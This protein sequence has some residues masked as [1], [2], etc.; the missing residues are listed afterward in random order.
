MPPTRLLWSLLAASLVLNVMYGAVAGVLVPAQIAIA[1]PTGKELTLAVVMTVSS[2]LTFVVHPLVGA[3]SDR[4]RSRWGRRTPWILGGAVASALAMLWLGSATAVWAITLGWLVL[5]PLLNVVEAPLDAVV[6][7]RIDRRTRPRAA[8]VYGAAAAVGVGVGAVIAGAGVSAVGSVYAGLAAALVVTMLAFSWLAPE[9]PAAAVEMPSVPARSAWAD[10]D[11]RLVFAGRFVL[12]LGHQL[13][14]GYL[15]YVVMAFTGSS[16]ADAAGLV[17]MVIGVHLVSIVIGAVAGARLIRDRRVPWIVGSTVVLA[18]SLALP[19]LAPNLAGLLLFAVVGG[20]GR[21][22]YLSADLALML[23][24]LPSSGD[25]GRDL[26]VLGLATI[27]PQMLAP[28]VAGVVLTVT[29][30]YPLL[31]GLASVVVLVSV[32]FMVRVG[33]LASSSRP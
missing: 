29:G 22:V 28:A 33:A 2:A 11:F 8:A 14:L 9:S 17:S 19:I 18:V 31:L 27:V 16:V 3:L 4:T 6:A 1:D 30:S 15:L 32:P 12:V 7:D 13:V 24:V 20:L 25:H 5:Q 23:D 26:G 21:G 10:R